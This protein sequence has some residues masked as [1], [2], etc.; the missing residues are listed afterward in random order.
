M[1]KGQLAREIAL[2]RPDLVKKVGINGLKKA[3][4]KAQS[5]QEALQIL[6]GMPPKGQR[7]RRQNGP[8]W[9]DRLVSL[10]QQVGDESPEDLYL[11]LVAEGYERSLD[12]FRWDLAKARKQ[13]R[14]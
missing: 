2:S 8:N 3:L 14:G 6:E 1:T 9:V 13:M 4:E 10:I 12:S 11:L 5:V 7:G